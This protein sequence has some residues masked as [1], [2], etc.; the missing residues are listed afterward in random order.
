[1]EDPMPEQVETPEGA[2]DPV[3]SPHWSRLL[4]GPVALWREEPMLEQSAPEGLHPMGETHA[5]AVC[6][7]L[8][9]VG[10]THVGEVGGGLSPVGGTPQ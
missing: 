9:P 4:E 6:E 3:G 7:E 5:G 8:Q 1:M 2:C 10:R